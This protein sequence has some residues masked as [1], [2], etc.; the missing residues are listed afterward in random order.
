MMART[1]L[2]LIYL[3]R[4]NAAVFNKYASDSIL[5]FCSLLRYYLTVLN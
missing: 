3:I 1:L 4:G 5:I 2:K